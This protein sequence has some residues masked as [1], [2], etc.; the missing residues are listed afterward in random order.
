[1]KKFVIVGIVMVLLMMSIGTA[2]NFDNVGQF[3]KSSKYGKYTIENMFGFGGNI[4]EYEL[5][6][7]TDLCFKSCEAEG[8]ATLYD[9]TELFSDVEFRGANGKTLNIKGYEFYVKDYVTEVVTE[10]EYSYVCEEVVYKNNSV[11][12]ECV[13]EYVGK[14]D[15]TKEYESWVKYN[16]EELNAGEYEWKIVGQKEK[17]QSVDWVATSNG[18]KL[19]KWAWWNNSFTYKQPIVLNNSGNPASVL[20]YTTITVNNFDTS[21]PAKF[22]QTNSHN[23]EVVCD[24][25]QVDKVIVNE[26]DIALY[27][28]VFGSGTGWTQAGTTFMFRLPFEIAG[29]VVN[30]TA[31]EIY[32][33][34]LEHDSVY[35]NLSNIG[36]LYDDFN[37]PDK[38][39]LDN[40][41]AEEGAGNNYFEIVSNMA[42]VVGSNNGV[43]Y[44]KLDVGDC[45][46]CENYEL[47]T[48]RV[49]GGTVGDQVYT[50]LYDGNP[51]FDLSPDELHLNGSYSW[52]DTNSNTTTI[53]L[54]NNGSVIKKGSLAYLPVDAYSIFL[55][56]IETEDDGDY[57]MMKNQ[58]PVNWDVTNKNATSGAN[59][60]YI[61]FIGNRVGDKIDYVFM[62]RAMMPGFEVSLEPEEYNGVVTV[63][64]VDPLNNYLSNNPT[65]TFNCSA[66][67]VGSN[68]TNVSM[69]LDGVRVETQ[70]MN[71][72]NFDLYFNRVVADGDHDWFCDAYLQNG[73]NDSDGTR[74]F[75]IDTTVPDIDLT[76]PVGNV[77]LLPDDTVYTNWS[78]TEVNPDACWLVYD[79]VNYSVPCVDLQKVLSRT[80]VTYMEMWMNDTAGNVGMD[81]ETFSWNIRVNVNNQAGTLVTG[82]NSNF[83]DLALSYTENPITRQFDTF[84]NGYFNFSTAVVITD[85][86]GFNN[87]FNGEVNF[88]AN[89]TEYNFTMVAKQLNLYFEN[90]SNSPYNASGFYTDLNTTG[91]FTNV[92]QI[93]IPTV[94]L[95]EGTVYVRFGWQDDLLN[96]SQFYEFNNQRDVGLEEN[97]SIL[98]NRSF[99]KYFRVMDEN[100]KPVEDASI[101]ISAMAFGTP[102]NLIGQRFTD[103]NGF[104]Y[105]WVDSKTIGAYYVSANGYELAS[106]KF[107]TNNGEYNMESLALDIFLNTENAN[108]YQY[109]TINV[110]ESYFVPLNTTAV[111]VSVY[112]PTRNEVTYTTNYRILNGYSN[113]TLC[114]LNKY[115]ECNGVL[116]AGSDMWAT[117]TTEDLNIT[118]WVD[119][120]EW[121]T[122]TL[123]NYSPDYSMFNQPSGLDED[124][125]RGIAFFFLIA[126]TG[127]LGMLI[128]PENEGVGSGIYGKDIFFMGVVL[129]NIIF[130]MQFIKMLIIVGIYYGLTFLRRIISE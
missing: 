26:T 25:S 4:A 52:F 120:Y 31:C 54:V 64:Q 110:Y 10:D 32:Y 130:P 67:S 5:T 16:F 112:A 41:W 70:Y 62:V 20:K 82:A 65:V 76:N 117:N 119:G 99:K 8:V 73:N 116:T 80:N 24:G 28:P 66:T 118:F 13:R 81:S 71:E 75:T 95:S 58:T 91:V 94:N 55:Y 43:T 85:S 84:T 9:D 36:L 107:E 19:D 30:D 27:N 72:V 12:T 103:S 34:Y 83:T 96:Y 128:K 121:G 105:F 129:I 92:T 97:I 2:M 46:D 63:T 78:Y 49:W 35:N 38:A 108:T 109:A 21:D 45:L 114:E 93:N 61:K 100:G 126:L 101:R 44:R 102:Y 50:G 125:L 90:Y 87:E 74:Q 29:G 56:G 18:V 1:M 122:V 22:N 17:W 14:I 23:F 86:D 98:E 111:H 11:G 59:V 124:F 15:V 127:I 6:S 40:G 77:G 88:Y 68:L 37:R 57:M 39:T 47:Q 48:G 7:N 123:E 113:N 42:E 104:T 89:K 33:G 3:E 69:W 51:T 53:S 115:F 60:T 106:D 79:N